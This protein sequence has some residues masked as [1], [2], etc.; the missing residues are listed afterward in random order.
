MSPVTVTGTLSI[1][2]SN[3]L[4]IEAGVTVLFASEARI[5]SKGVV[6]VGAAWHCDPALQIPYLPLPFL[7]Q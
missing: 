5:I 2:P 3:E 1:L 7:P 4:V 6:R